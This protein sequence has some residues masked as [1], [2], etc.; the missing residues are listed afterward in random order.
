MTTDQ[1]RCRLAT[2]Y[3]GPKW[4]LK[5]Q[6]MDNRQVVAIYKDMQ[7]TDRLVKKPRLKKE[8]GIK[9]CEQ[10]TIWDLL[11]EENVH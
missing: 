8:P 7:R 5:V 11:G 9:Y 6:E 3:P 10:I 2:L 4:K 1:M